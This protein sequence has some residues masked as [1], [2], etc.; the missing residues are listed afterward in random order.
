MYYTETVAAVE[1]S[2][3]TPVPFVLLPNA[4]WHCSFPPGS[5]YKNNLFAIFKC[6]DTLLRSCPR[7]APPRTTE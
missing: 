3:K 5:T 2:S 1:E 7:T 4:D 6:L